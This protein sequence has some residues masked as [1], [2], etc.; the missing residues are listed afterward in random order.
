MSNSKSRD[1]RPPASRRS[2]LFV[3]GADREALLAGPRS[4]ADVLI[5]E[6]EDFVPA[7]RRPE[8][9]ALCAEVVAAWRAAGVLAAVRV[10]PFWDGGLADLEAAMGA[11]PDIIALPK[12][13]APEH[14]VQLDR[15][16]TDLERRHGRPAGSTELLPNIESARGL[17]QT[18]DIAKSSP[19]ITACL[20][21]SE[22]MAADLG[23]AR[24]R[25]GAELAYARA[26]FHLEY[27]AAGVVSVDCP[28]TYADAAGAEAETETARGLGF[29]A[30]SAALPAHI[31][32]INRVFTPDDGAIDQARA[33]IAAFEAARRAGNDRAEVAGSLVEKPAYHAAGR[34]LTRARML[35]GV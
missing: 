6:M 19:R 25:D 1:R 22:D 33:V 7:D 26:R 14:M 15:A 29:T 20:I 5:Q 34:L 16:V 2:W 4:G 8:A 28:Y 27:V 13:S 23:A 9:R 31:A 24:S 17:M 11:G 30:K 10:N 35:G 32:I 12:V 18:Y 3:P 21:A